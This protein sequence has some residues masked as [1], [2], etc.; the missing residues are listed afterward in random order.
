MSS[1]GQNNWYFLIDCNQFFV[2]CEQLFNPKL[3][4]KPTV[5]LSSND[6]CVVSRSKEAKE[7]GIPMG[8]PLYQL[9]QL[10][11]RYK[12]H[13]LSS[14]FELYGDMS[15]RVMQV[16]STF[17]PD[18]EE[19]SID[20]AFLKITALNPL[21]IAIQIKAAVERLTGIPVSIGIG[22]TKTLAKVAGDIAKKK[23][24]GCFFLHDNV[25]EIL[26]K[27][28]PVDIWGIGNRIAAD[29]KSYHIHTAL[30][31]KKADDTWIQKKFSV[32]LLRTV[33]ELRGRE[34]IKHIEVDTPRKSITSSKSFG[35]PVTELTDLEEAVS[36]YMAKAS[37]KLRK[38]GS[39]AKVICVFISTSRFQE[40]SYYNYRI[41]TLPQ[42]SDYTPDLISY[43]K[44]AL[45]Q[46]FKEG[47]SYKKAGVT[48]FELSPKNCVQLD[49][50][51]PPPS[52]NTKHSEAMQVLDKIK[53]RLGK[54]AICFASE[55]IDKSWKGKQQ[56]TSSRFTT[57]WDELLT[58]KI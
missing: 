38:E 36:T 13:A 14:N 57:R 47:Y 31:V 25:D 18:M 51:S 3:L 22:I 11:K 24:S 56:H 45:K 23:S 32:V 15:F 46:I 40:D 10:M 29:L 1:T 50:F 37:S 33:W 21:P 52:T 2:S 58:I 34:C 42:S 8:A 39:L 12:V 9:E 26:A 30:D 27:L 7:I 55:G 48:L 49:L 16:L 6:G 20:E 17:S 44:S 43:A 28:S 54:D 53:S 35:R 41:I 5:V 4:G 19:Y